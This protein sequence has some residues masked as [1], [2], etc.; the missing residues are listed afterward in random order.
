MTM[1]KR[2]SKKES[3][4][5]KI[6][7]LNNEIKPK[8][9][10]LGK[11]VTELSKLEE[12][13]KNKEIKLILNRVQ[14]PDGTILTSR[15]RHDYVSH[16]DKNG[17]TY[18]VDGGL[19]Y[20]RYTNHKEAPFK[21]LSVYSNAPFKKIRESFYRGGRGKDGTEPLKWVPMCE[22][23]DEWV[24][25]CIEYNEDLGM[26]DSLANELYKKELAYRKKHKIKITE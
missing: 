15:H 10:E 25:A 4:Q 5:N 23:N 20:Q 9:A 8:L 3:L 13:P 21:N 14:T 24:K 12:R 16:T 22:M 1:K 17:L 18:M 19:D 7:A 2:I 26:G 6:D 11:L